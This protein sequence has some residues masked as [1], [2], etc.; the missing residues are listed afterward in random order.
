MIRL[1]A[2]SISIGPLQAKFKPTPEERDAAWRIMVELGTGIATQPFNEDTGLIRGV[3][4]SLHRTFLLTKEDLRELRPSTFDGDMNFASV[5]MALLTQCLGPFLAKWHEP[6]QHHETA[7]KDGVSE[8]SHE[9]V[10]SDR[11][12]FLHDLSNLQKTTFAFTQLLSELA[13]VSIS[14]GREAH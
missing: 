7:R 10:W 2:V 1:E 12:E 14:S 13:G 11:A 6:L 3:L 9:K 4:S 5:C 8:L